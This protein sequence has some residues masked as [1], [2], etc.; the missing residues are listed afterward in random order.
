MA[1]MKELTVTMENKPGTLA[2]MAEA[3]G[4]AKVSILAFMT[5]KA[6]GQSRVRRVT[7]KL[8][9]A[10]KTMAGLNLQASEE[11]VVGV[12]LANRPGTLSDTA[13]KLVSAGINI[14]HGYT[15]AE[16]ARRAGCVRRE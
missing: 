8:A 11:E 14:N 1:K 5:E 2:A 7:D 6:E 16:E 3:L 10:I 4:K 13:G 9:K 12:T 15:G